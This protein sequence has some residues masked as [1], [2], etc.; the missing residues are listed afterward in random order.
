TASSTS[1]SEPL[2]LIAH[3]GRQPL[4]HDW[5]LQ[6]HPPAL[7]H[8]QATA[9]LSLAAHNSSDYPA[10][11]TSGQSERAAQPSH[12]Q[13]VETDAADS[14]GRAD[15]AAASSRHDNGSRRDSRCCQSTLL[16]G[17][18]VP[19]PEWTLKWSCI[20]PSANGDPHVFFCEICKKTM[21]CAHQGLRDVTRHLESS[22]HHKMNL[23]MS[24]PISTKHPDLLS[25]SLSLQALRDSGELS[26]V[27]TPPPHDD[28]SDDRES[29]APSKGAPASPSPVA[30]AP[31]QATQAIAAANG[32]LNPA[33]K[34]VQCPICF[35]V[36]S[37]KFSLEMHY[38]IHQGLKPYTCQHCGR[39]FRQKGTLMR[40]KV[41][42]YTRIAHTPLSQLPRTSLGRRRSAEVNSNSSWDVL[43]EL[44]DRLRT[45]TL[46][47]VGAAAVHGD[48]VTRSSFTFAPELSCV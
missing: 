15:T 48:D 33:L 3:P 14:G 36:F 32:Q 30:F 26:V 11:Q 22:G 13:P 18:A 8:D 46:P 39:S 17:G 10:D 1:N 41:R 43:V 40:H 20:L 28:D 7:R 45:Q 34:D 6:R 25:A 31:L 9:A 16:S 38:L 27:T 35:K 12:L 21:S 29:D 44:V 2:P 23:T 42:T 37:R 24:L 4:Q 19:G 47:P 5:L